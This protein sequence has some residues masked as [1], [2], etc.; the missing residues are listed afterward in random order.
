MTLDLKSNYSTNKA[1]ELEGVWEDLGGDAR[2]LVARI[3]NPKFKAEY[4]KL[5]RAMRN[6]IESGRLTGDDIDEKISTILAKTIL[7][8]WENLTDG[9]EDIEYSV[10]NATKMMF[11][12]PNFR[13]EVWDF[14][15]DTQRFHDEELEEDLGNSSASSDGSSSSED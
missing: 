7:L 3:G 11:E 15:N 12:Y 10:E 6:R 13:D 8:D 4:R 2:I 9:G 5:P 1:K 14:A